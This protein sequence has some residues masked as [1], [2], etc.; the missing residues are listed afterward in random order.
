MASVPHLHVNALEMSPS[1]HRGEL[2]SPTTEALHELTH[3]WNPE[4][5]QNEVRDTE[6]RLV[7]ARGG[8][9][10]DG[11]WVKEAKRYKNPV[12]KSASQENVTSSWGLS[13]VTLHCTFGS[14]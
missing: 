1:G 14:C 5:K 12:R 13:S 4:T 3:L 10:R 9:W 7:V 8:V 6:N 11:R 2:L